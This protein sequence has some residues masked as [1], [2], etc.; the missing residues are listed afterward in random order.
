VE[1]TIQQYG[2]RVILLD[3]LMTAISAMAEKSSEKYEMQSQFTKKIT[4]IAMKYNVI[5]ILVAHKK[6]NTTGFDEMD[7]ILGSSDVVNLASVVLSYG[8]DREINEDQRMLK[9]LKNRLFGKVNYFGWV[10]D[11][12]EKSNRIYGD[13]D[14]VGREFEWTKLIQNEQQSFL[15]ATDMDEIPFD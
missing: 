15:N 5:I 6:K 14:D 3:N 1:N 13:G 4:E 7:D 8:R 11:F 2:V 9:L 10:M 12:D